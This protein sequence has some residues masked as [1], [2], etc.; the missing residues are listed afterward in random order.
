LEKAIGIQIMQNIKKDET[1]NDFLEKKIKEIITEERD[2]IRKALSPVNKITIPSIYPRNRSIN[3]V[4]NNITST[5]LQPRSHLYNSINSYNSISCNYHKNKMFLP[6]KKFKNKKKIFIQTNPVIPCR[7]ENEFIRSRNNT[8][9]DKNVSNLRIK[10]HRL[11]PRVLSNN[12]YGHVRTETVC[13]GGVFNNVQTTYIIYSKNCNKSS[14]PNN[15][16]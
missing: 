5:V 7:E 8:S 16:L 13:T 4:H 6:K 12:D 15:K 3:H 11:I 14:I 1:F 9:L 2:N 10:N